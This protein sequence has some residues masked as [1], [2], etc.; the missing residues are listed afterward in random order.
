MA[1]YLAAEVPA[2]FERMMSAT[3]AEFLRCLQI[4]LPPGSVDQLRADGCRVRADE[5]ELLLDWA[6]AGERRIGLLALPQL[7]V[8][9]RFARGDADT[10]AHFLTRLDRAMQRGGG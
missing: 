1:A 4:A 7:Q 3:P 5:L 10:R 6:P 9:Y 8:H 2:A